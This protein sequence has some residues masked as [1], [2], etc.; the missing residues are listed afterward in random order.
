MEVSMLFNY[1]TINTILVKVLKGKSI[2]LPN[3]M[4][5]VI[6]DIWLE[7]TFHKNDISEKFHIVLK[8]KTSSRQVTCEN[9][10]VL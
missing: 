2:I 4:K 1:Y 3:G 9:F 5:G 8:D 7:I 6:E 10:T